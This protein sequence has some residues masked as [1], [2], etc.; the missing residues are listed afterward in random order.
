MAKS[1]F[2][3]AAALLSAL[4]ATA[5]CGKKGPPEH[6]PDGNYPTTYPTR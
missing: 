2:L 6:V 1:R 5:A 4:L 3:I